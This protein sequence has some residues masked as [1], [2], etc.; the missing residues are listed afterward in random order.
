MS[1]SLTVTA[2]HPG[3]PRW[4]LIV[5]LSIL[6]WLAACSDSPP[7]APSISVQPADTAATV[8]STAT[9]SVGA[10]GPDIG[11]QWQ[12][13]SDGGTSWSDLGGAT[14]A[15]YTTPATTLADSGQRFRVVVSGAGISLTSSAVELTVTAAPVAPVLTVQPSPQAATPPNAASFSVT[16]AGTALAYQWQRST[17]GGT[18]WAELAG[19]TTASYGTGATE[20]SMNGQLFRVVVSNGAGSVTSAAVTLSVGAAPVAAAF[21]LQPADQAVSAGSAAA[22]TVAVTG[23]P[24]P[25]LQWQRSTDGG[26]TWSDI[27]AATDSSY[28]TGLT[29]L[30]QTGERYRAAASNSAGSA[31]SDAALLSVNPAAQAPA[32]T[33]QPAD[34][35]VTAPAT[36]SFSAAASGVPT[37]TW[38]W[39][40]SGDGGSTWANINGATAASY[41][42]PGTALADSGKR[43][44]A[45]ASNASGTASSQATTLTV[46][47]APLGKA[48]QTA[49]LIESGDA[50]EAT[51][52]QLAVN[53]QGDAIAVWQQSDG[54]S[55]D[56]YANR[57]TAAAG[58]G[59]A[60]RIETD[61]AGVAQNAQVAIDSSGNAIA[62]WQQRNLNGRDDIWANRYTAG[63]GWGTASLIEA[64]AFDA[65]NPQLG[66]DASGNVIAVWW[67]SDGSRNNLVSNRY[68]PATGWGTAELIET[69][70]SGDVSAP[71]IAIDASGNAV[72]VWARSSI[73]SYNV[74]ANRYAAGT[75]W[76][77]AAA[78]DSDQSNAPNPA[79]H[80]AIDASGNAIAVW[81]RPDGSWDSIWSNRFSAGVGWGTA[82]LVE[83]DNSNSAR[84]ARVAFDGSGNAIAVWTQSF[85]GVANVMV[86][87][88]T[89]ATGWGSAVLIE[90]DD[91]GA[92]FEPRLVIDGSGNATAVWSQRNVAGFTFNIWANRFSAGTGWGSAMMIDNDANP[93]RVPQLGVDAGG[94]LVAVWQQVS[95]G[96]RPSIWANSF[97]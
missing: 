84:D 35:S 13:S 43:Y 68:V 97:R 67:Q 18:T 73:G 51:L 1:A 26:S 32:I 49:M 25:T 69:E 10:S 36:A 16:A 47:A 31:T 23:T 48:W 94:N 56:I 4:L 72:A 3:Q 66:I 9:L 90:T 82:V 81:H 87:H 38:Q 62:V 27:A 96:V 12:L 46:A 63:S 42:T 29:L 58:W 2:R 34:Q 91:A 22:F 5:L 15:S 89:A 19:A 39:Q 83:T 78:I 95:G 45:V 40:L 11:Y 41:T 60:A 8:G 64:G 85:G 70:N 37:P 59:A 14:Q 21:S 92:A 80:V 53:A 44:R 7:P 74:W 88:Y 61:N 52:P 50:G 24:T 55:I 65:G 20:L 77:N 17:D 54:V 6:T 30:A 75:G 33:T 57:Y 86:N 71:Q 93:A 79:P 76:G 28:N